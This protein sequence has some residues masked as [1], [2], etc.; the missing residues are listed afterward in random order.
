LVRVQP[1]ELD[2]SQPRAKSHCSIGQVCQ[3]YRRGSRGA[4]PGA[5]LGIAETGNEHMHRPAK[6]ESRPSVRELGLGPG[7]EPN[8]E[9]LRCA[10][11]PL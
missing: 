1:G 8:A 9:R 4:Y 10:T 11:R 6:F 5:Y 3:E 2:P 7:G